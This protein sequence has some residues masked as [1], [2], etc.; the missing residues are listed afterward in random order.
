MILTLNIDLKKLNEEK[1]KLLDELL[2][3]KILPIKSKYRGGD[4][5]IELDPY[6]KWDDLPP[7]LKNKARRT[8]IN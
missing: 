3:Q 6:E 2:Y 1:K 5:A 7:L 4:A 8:G